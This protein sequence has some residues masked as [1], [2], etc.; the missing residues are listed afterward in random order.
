MKEF[1]WRFGRK[2]RKPAVA[3]TDFLAEIRSEHFS[4][5]SPFLF[6]ENLVI[7]GSQMLIFLVRG[8]SKV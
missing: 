5:A 7:S 4:R 6:G 3:M 2:L 1:L 8:F